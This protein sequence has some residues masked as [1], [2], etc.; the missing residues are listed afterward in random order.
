MADVRNGFTVHGPRN[1]RGF[2]FSRLPFFPRSITRETEAE[3]LL[4]DVG[5]GIKICGIARAGYQPRNKA[6]A[7]PAENR[8]LRFRSAFRASCW[9][10]AAGVA[11]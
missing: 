3:L 10:N 2:I 8:F 1:E 9:S 11:G 7:P 5:H 6:W 4:R